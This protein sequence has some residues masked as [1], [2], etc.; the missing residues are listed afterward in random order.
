MKILK[1][2]YNEILKQVKKLSFKVCL[3]IVLLF[4]ISMPILYKVFV[5]DDS[6]PL[7]YEG[8][9]Q[10]YQDQIISD[11]DTEQDKLFNKL[12]DIKINI[13]NRA[14]E[15]D[16]DYTDFNSMLYNEYISS[17]T[18][19]TIL[20]SMIKDEDINYNEIDGWFEIDSNQY[21]DYSVQQ[22]QD[23]KNEIEEYTKDLEGIIDTK[24]YSWYL[25]V[26]RSYYEDY[27]NE[28]DKMMYDLYDKL[29]ELNIKDEND[30]RVIEAQNIIDYYN[31]KEI[32]ISEKDYVSGDSNLSYDEYVKLTNMKNDEMDK[33]IE[34]SFYAI[35][36]N[37]NYNGN[38]LKTTFNDTIQSNITILSIVIV[39]IAGGIVANEF[40][41]GTIRLLVIRPNKRWKILLSKFL[42]VVAIV[43]GLAFITYFATF[44]TSGISFGFNNYF[45][46]DLNVVNGAVI[47]ESYI[48]NSICNTLLQLIPV[49]FVGL[50]AFFLSTVINNTAFSVGFSIFILM[51]SQLA[52]MVL[53]L[54]GFPFIDLTFLPYLDFAQFINKLDLV[55]NCQMFGIYYTLGK[56]I[57]VLISWSIIIYLISTFV[58]NKKDIRN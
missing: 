19:S 2:T 23:A 34:K 20:D 5:Y 46:S 40:Q 9:I 25:Q 57:I 30:F 48:F 50:G 44:I 33:N 6:F 52:I 28:N 26:Q 14:L 11:A 49:I 29:I 4:A 8:D 3:I 17:K 47:Q 36:N 21:L 22:L 16:E 45:V 13:I 55:S 54:L 41:K 37:I 10:Y 27:S 31:Q 51:G 12:L 24:D 15:N 1:L 38:G 18:M 32:L 56:G 43:L 39:I 7:Y 42:A 58:F 53:S 35:E